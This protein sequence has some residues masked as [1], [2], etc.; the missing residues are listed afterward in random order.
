MTTSTD[1]VGSA[2]FSRNLRTTYERL[3]E[4]DLNEDDL[5]HVMAFG[6]RILTQPIEL[7]DGVEETLRRLAEVH[8]LTVMTKGQAE[9][10]QMKIDRSGIGSYFRH[11]EIVPEKDAASYRFL[12]ESI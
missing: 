9:E 1:R 10:Q 12:A 7:I 4:R 3:A 5:R 8:D 2:A 11:A 6:E